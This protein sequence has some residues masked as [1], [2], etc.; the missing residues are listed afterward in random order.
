M[1][2]TDSFSERC[3]SLVIISLSILQ[4]LEG[5][6]VFKVNVSDS[7]GIIPLRWVHLTV[8][9]RSSRESHELHHVLGESARLI[10][11]DKVHHAQLLVEVRGLAFGFESF[12][13]ADHSPIGLNESSLEELDHF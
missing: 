1:T 2:Q 6:L 3:N 5:C 13:R 10:R 7:H 9:Y 8:R 4:V 11:E 12:L